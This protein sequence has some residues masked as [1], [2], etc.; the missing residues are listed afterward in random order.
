MFFIHVT[1][2]DYIII[3]MNKITSSNKKYLYIV[4]YRKTLKIGSL[5][6]LANNKT[7]ALKQ[8]DLRTKLQLV[9]CWSAMPGNIF[10]ILISL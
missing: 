5:C 9:R 7:L 6:S 1:F 3:I 8:P 2:Y 10:K 4:N